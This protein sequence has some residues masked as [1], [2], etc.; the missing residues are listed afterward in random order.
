M[1]NHLETLICQFYEWKGW[2]VRRNVKVGPLSHGG[3]AGEL[4]VV[5]YNPTTQEVIHYEPS[6]DASPWTARAARAKKKLEVGRKHILDVLPWLPENYRLR[7]VAV[8]FNAPV[9]LKKGFSELT[10]GEVMTIDALVKTI[11]DEV[12]ACGRAARHAIPEQ[13]D[14]LRT[15]QLVTCGYMKLE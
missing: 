13:Y 8:F 5:V 15:I 3:F 14:L 11:R 9:H 2:V 4:D 7:Q 10:G 6:L 12:K 1:A